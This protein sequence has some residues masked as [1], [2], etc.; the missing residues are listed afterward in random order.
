MS[1][2]ASSTWRSAGAIL[3]C[4]SALLVL[5]YWPTV[6]SLVAMWRTSTYS[7]GAVVIPCAAYLVWS[8]RKRLTKLQPAPEFWAL[9]VLAALSFGW[10]LG[11][12]TATNAL[13]QFCLVTM[14][15]VMIW[16]QVGTRAAKALL[17]PLAFLL[18]AIPMGDG[19]IPALQDLSARIAVKLLDFSR[20]PVLSEGLYISVP[21]GKWEVAE[22]CSGVRYLYASLVVGFLFAG[23]AY[24]SWVRRV[25]FLLASAVVPILANGVRVYG[26]ILL[27]YLGGSRVA[28]GVDHVLAGFLFFSIVTAVLIAL[29]LRW[30]EKPKPD[31]AEVAVHSP[32]ASA[33]ESQGPASSYALSS[34]P[35]RGVSAVLAIA[36]L[37]VPPVSAHFIWNRLAGSAA[38]ELKP[39]GVSPPWK[40]VRWDS[41]DWRPHYLEP[42]SEIIQNYEFGE[43]AVKLYVAYYAPSQRGTKLASSSNRLFDKPE[44]W[45]AR[46]GNTA[47]DAAGHAFRAHVTFIRSAKRSLMI[48]SWYWVDGTYTESDYAAKLLLAKARLFGSR[49]GSAAIALATDGGT[50]GSQTETILKDFL[51][52]VSLEASLRAAP[53]ESH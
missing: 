1:S 29:G 13:Q 28:L 3:L 41:T 9:P 21:Y 44:W 17:M 26:I 10:L 20:I 42:S 50:P 37:G 33:P 32:G 30:R 14:L 18:F 52:H 49:E 16:S 36:V 34:L 43:H 24:R 47:L 19:L 5:L 15:I 51:S 31:S 35:R 7:Y 46:E 11:Q 27:G 45:R 40:P 53:D 38:G 23:L 12:L 6:V 48:W 22:A 8:R 39:P 2:P 25:S 4:S